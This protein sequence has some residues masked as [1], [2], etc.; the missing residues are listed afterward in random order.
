MRI[1]AISKRQYMN[2]DLLDD[3]YGR[4]REIPLAL[5]RRGHEVHGLCLS[6]RTRTDTRI[7]DTDPRSGANVSWTS[8]N[9]GKLLVPGLIRFLRNGRRLVQ[10][11]KP[12]VIWAGSDSFYGPLALFIGRHSGTRVV[13][14]IYDHFETFASTR[15]PGLFAL[16]RRACRDAEG[17][18]SFSEAM[19]RHITQ[20]Y[21]RSGPLLTLANGTDRTL[22]RPLDKPRCR[23]RLGLPASGRLLGIAGAIARQRGIETVFHA[24]EVLARD[25]PDL[26]L[27]IAGP[28]DRDLDI[29]AHPRLHDLGMLAH[30][31]VPCVLN[32]LDIGIVPHRDSPAGRFGFPYKAYEMMACGL[33][34]VAANVGA[35]RG[36]LDECP[37]CLYKPD[38]PDD[39]GRAIRYQLDAVRVATKP[40]PDWNDIAGMFE[41]FLLNLT[42]PASRPG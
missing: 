42:D 32:A 31:D 9:V 21:R 34:L 3:R 2:R 40:V 10:Q 33:P 35:M 1:L 30:T 13:F 8:V 5:A 38:D 15:V 18:T 17:V 37:E 11:L 25:A 7:V 16:Y 20:V 22:F 6:Y 26:H 19:S 29:P 14:D 4:F 23:D 12:D 36:L 27:V 39:L 28:R 24:F 41:G